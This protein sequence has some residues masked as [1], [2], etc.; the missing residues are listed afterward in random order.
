MKR[1]ISK[2]LL[3]VG[4]TSLV[5][6]GCGGGG[7][8]SGDGNRTTRTNHPPTVQ[9]NASAARVNV[10][11]RV[12]LLGSG[13]DADGDTLT[14]RWSWS[15]RPGGSSAALENANT[16]EAAFIPD[17]AGE[18]VARLRVDD[19]HDSAE[20]RVTITV[21]PT[22]LFRLKN[23]AVDNEPWFTNGTPEG[24]VLAADLN[25]FTQNGEIG[26]MVRLGSRIFFRA[27]DG[28]HGDELWVHDAEG[29][30]MVKDIRPGAGS[31]TP[32]Y[33]TVFD[34]MV[35][36]SAQQ[37]RNHVATLLVSD[38]TE[39]GTRPVRTDTPPL[40][41]VELAAAGDRL[42]FSASTTDTGGN[43]L[44]YELWESDGTEAGTRMV[45]DIWPG[46]D[47]SAPR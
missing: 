30:H 31:S 44:G 34:G 2:S 7:A 6:I 22:A 25:R 42:Y 5:L 47:S 38:G 23:K 19:G 1:S 43:P 40:S 16:K 11:Q 15:S 26:D 4:I 33:L 37:D 12:A 41:P 8:P 24:T 20:K 28:V 13:D 35:Y 39:A 17:V 3:A 45:A 9:V 27:D 29:T 14:Y 36:F 18:Y 32:Q 21:R 46:W 10:Y